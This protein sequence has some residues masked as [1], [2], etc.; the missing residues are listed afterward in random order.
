MN[1]LARNEPNESHDPDSHHNDPKAMQILRVRDVRRVLGTM[2]ASA[3][4]NSAYV[5]IIGLLVWD[6]SKSKLNLGWIGLIEFMPA[7]LLVFVSGLVADRY[8]RRKTVAL[9]LGAQMAIA[10]IISF[11]LRSKLDSVTPIFILVFFSGICFA[12]ISPA[13]RS[14]IPAAA[15]S[16]RALPRLV[17][18]SSICWQGG[19]ILGPVIGAFVYRSNPSM[20]FRIIAVGYGLAIVGVLRVSRKAGTDHLG[21]ADQEAP[22]FRSAFEGLAMMRKQPILM[23]AISLDLFAVLFGGAVAL[24]PALADE[25]NWDK[26]SVGILRAAGGIGGAVVTLLLAAKPV[27][28]NIGKVLLG[29]VA[30]FGVA[31]IGFGLTKQLWVAI[32]CMALLNAADSVS[33]FIRSTLVPL[34]TPAEQRG[35]VSAVEGVFIGAS[36]ELGAFES[37]VA[38]RFLGTT[39]AIV[40]GGVLTIAVVG[41]CWF[42]FPALRDV[43][44]FADLETMRST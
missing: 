12:F 44:R 10:T 41:V 17:G 21:E 33:V 18:L 35:R 2:L 9:A 42:V 15:P 5:V 40:I 4:A 29:V 22:S 39:P 8:D 3:T 37:G 14:L 30:G 43:D 7:V 34:V 19:A 28:R 38:A 31:T 1:Q 27:R 24:L 25:R 11:L 26:S 20:A 6:L 16:E 23:G 36:N 13:M 32:G